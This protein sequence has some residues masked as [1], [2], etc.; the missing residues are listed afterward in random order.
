M[1]VKE[2]IFFP[3]LIDI[4]VGCRRRSSSPPS[5][6]APDQLPGLVVGW[7]GADQDFGLS[8]EPLPVVIWGR[9]QGKG[10]ISR[11]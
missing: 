5:T 9:D 3:S 6:L 10:R 11:T 8:P 7:C 4:V 1:R 2:F